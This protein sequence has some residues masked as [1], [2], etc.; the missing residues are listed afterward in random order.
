MVFGQFFL[1]LPIPNFPPGAQIVICLALLFLFILVIWPSHISLFLLMMLPS[2]SCL[3]L[4]MIV[5]FG[6]LF[7][8]ETGNFLLSHLWCAASSLLPFATV[9]GHVSAPYSSVLSTMD[10]Y[11]RIGVYATTLL[12]YILSN[13]PNTAFALPNA[14]T[15]FD[16]LEPNDLYL[17]IMPL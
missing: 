10:S 8:H 16:F 7:L 11:N 2:S 13:L 5:L 14:H 4:S 1:G 15:C 17:I 3:V 12:F 9:I 6:I